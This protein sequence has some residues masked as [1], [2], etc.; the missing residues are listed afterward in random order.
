MISHYI[1]PPHTFKCLYAIRT[2]MHAKM[3]S[4]QFKWYMDSC[5]PVV[6]SQRKIIV[7]FFSQISSRKHLPTRHEHIGYLTN[8][9]KNGESKIC[10]SWTFLFIIICTYIENSLYSF[11]QSSQ[12]LYTLFNYTS[13][14]VQNILI[15]GNM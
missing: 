14:P 6:E 15:K 7:K 2:E 8:V 11:R 13:I 3:D 9:K 1:R 4:M 5:I 12:A 10:F